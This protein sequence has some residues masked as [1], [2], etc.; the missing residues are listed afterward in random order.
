MLQSIKRGS[1]GDAPS[2][3]LGVDGTNISLHSSFPGKF[4][5]LS[6]R[7]ITSGSD[8][9]DADLIDV[10]DQ[11][12]QNYYGPAFGA[13]KLLTAAAM[14]GSGVGIGGIS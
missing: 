10:V 6:Y 3:G 2:V 1:C 14:A 12:A 13:N 11:R 5:K 9:G 8:S 4:Q 7:T